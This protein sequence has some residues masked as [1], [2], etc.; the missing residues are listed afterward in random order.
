MPL[1]NYR[2]RE[3]DKT[4]EEINLQKKTVR[5]DINAKILTTDKVIAEIESFKVEQNKK[6]EVKLIKENK[7]KRKNI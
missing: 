7:K 1:S 2:I 5:L 6:K 3:S 4:Y